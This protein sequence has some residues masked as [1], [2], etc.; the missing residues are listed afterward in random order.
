MYPVTLW[1]K[2]GGL[3]LAAIQPRS[4]SFGLFLLGLCKGLV[5]YKQTDNDFG[6]VKKY[7]LYFRLASRGSRHFLVGYPELPEAFRASYGEGGWSHR[8]FYNLNCLTR[9][10]PLNFVHSTTFKNF[11]RRK[12]LFWKTLYIFWE[13]FIRILLDTFKTFSLP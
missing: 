11:F 1:S 5:L 10:L 9:V 7:H 6:S 3:E 13:N 12:R 2:G 8:K 4:Q